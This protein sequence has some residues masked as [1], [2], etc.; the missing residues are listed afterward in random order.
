MQEKSAVQREHIVVQSLPDT[1]CAQFSVQFCSER[2]SICRLV[3]LPVMS[4]L[5]QS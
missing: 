1:V 5:L 2:L 3:L 4:Q